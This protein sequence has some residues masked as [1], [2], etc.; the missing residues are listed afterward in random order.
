MRLMPS[1]VTLIYGTAAIT[2]VTSMF[3]WILFFVM[4]D[5]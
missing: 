3:G 2:L 1:G 4:D 5:Y